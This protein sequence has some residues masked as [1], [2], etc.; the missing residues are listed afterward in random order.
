MR[1]LQRR[2]TEPVVLSRSLRGLHKERR[3]AAISISLLG[4][5]TRPPPARARWEEMPT[6]PPVVV[7]DLNSEVLVR[8]R[9]EQAALVLQPAEED[10]RNFLQVLAGLLPVHLAR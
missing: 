5:A 1:R 8:S 4:L 6:L 9:L 10:R 3:P 2:Q 7:P